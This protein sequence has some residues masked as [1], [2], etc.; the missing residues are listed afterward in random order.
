MD[1]VVS[2]T[3]VYHVQEMI[4]VISGTLKYMP[5][6]LKCLMMVIQCTE[7]NLLN[8]VEINSLHTG[9]ANRTPIPTKMLSLTIN[10]CSK[11][12]NHI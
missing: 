8:M 2:I 3:Q 12:T 7:D 10:I 11:N 5:S 4:I 6:V 1:H 9:M